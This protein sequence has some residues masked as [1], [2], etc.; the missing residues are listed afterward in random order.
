MVERMV[1]SS[2]SWKCARR[3]RLRREV[4]KVWRRRVRALKSSVEEEV[5][6]EGL[7]VTE[8]FV[9]GVNKEVS[10]EASSECRASMHWAM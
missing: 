4:L 6:V 10:M 9:A 1:L 8:A 5:E 7:V 3:E 2:V